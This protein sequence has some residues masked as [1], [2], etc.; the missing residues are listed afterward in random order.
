MTWGMATYRYMVTPLFALL[1]STNWRL[2]GSGGRLIIHPV[3]YVI[4]A[5]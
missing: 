3:L 4:K 5:E 1:T 2:K